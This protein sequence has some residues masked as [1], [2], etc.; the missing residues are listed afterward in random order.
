[1]N[2]ALIGPPGS[3]K[4]SYGPLLA[5][6]LPATLVLVSDV[7]RQSDRF[8]N[9]HFAKGSLLDDATVTD[10]LLQFLLLLDNEKKKRLLLDGFPR[11]LQQNRMM[12]ESWP[13]ELQVRGAVFLDVPREVCRSKLLGRRLCTACGSN[14]NV[15]KVEYG[16]FVLPPNLP[17]NCNCR[18][19]F[20]KKREDDTSDVVDKRL[21]LH[22]NTI[23]PVLDLFKSKNTIFTFRPYRGYE[24]LEQNLQEW[25]KN[26]R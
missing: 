3:G 8:D 7:L 4:G 23:Q 17:K 1:M 2:L 26:R 22:F 12:Q 13:R 14:Y 24:G 25:L 11:T 6:A 21:D 19:E 16:K 5:R 20:W 9:S 18:R 10:A 15:A